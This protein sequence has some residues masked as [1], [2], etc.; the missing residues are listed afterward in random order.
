MILR[1]PMRVV[2]FPRRPLVMGIVNVNDDSFS[3][4]GISDVEMARRYAVS[5]A[6]AGADVIDVGVESARTN[7]PPV[8]ARE[9]IERF[10]RFF[11]GWKGALAGAGPADAEQV[12]PPVLSANTWRPEVAEAVL[13][14]GVELLND[15]GGVPD[16]RNA[17]ACARH[18][19]ALLIMHIAR[20]PKTEDRER[21]WE[22]IMRE[23]RRY[24]LAA[25]ARVRKAGLS[26]DQVVLDP[27]IG[28]AKQGRH[29][30][31]I[32]REA[33]TLTRFGRPVLL[34]VSR[35]AVIGETLGIGVPAERDAG[36]L[37]CIA[38][39]LRGGGSVFRVHDVSAAWQAVKA[40]RRLE[41]A[42]K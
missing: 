21:E 4:D 14:M 6:E 38:A 33:G 24:F 41:A 32:L 5:Q 42:R 23:L 20:A 10:G 1:L 16:L 17:R 8:P 7:R 22:D 11:E 13:D 26:P 35:K 9:E 31:C 36:T 15:M 28:F 25:M 29:D 18:G 37:A 30:L 12:W 40:M 3:G 2:R 34:P 27:G 19:A 39:G